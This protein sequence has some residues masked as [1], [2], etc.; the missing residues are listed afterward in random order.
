MA[1][2]LQKAGVI[3]LQPQ[4]QQVLVV[5]EGDGEGLRFAAFVAGQHAPA[6]V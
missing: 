4:V 3:A 1:V 5:L 2:G 6:E